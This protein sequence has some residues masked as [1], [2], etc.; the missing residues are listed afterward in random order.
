MKSTTRLSADKMLHFLPAVNKAK[1]PKFEVHLRIYDLNN[2]PLV[3]GVSQIK[4]HLPHSI[5]GEHRGRTGK[6]PISNHKV[7]YGYGKVVPVRIHIDRNNNLEECPIE[8]EVLQE[9]NEADERIVLGKVTLN[10]AEYVEESEAILRDRQ[11]PNPGTVSTGLGGIPATVAATAS[12]ATAA[13]ADQLHHQAGKLNLGHSR[14]RSSMSNDRPPPSPG[15]KASS[16]GNSTHQEVEAA[17]DVRE[18]IVRRHLMQESKINSTLKVGILMIQIDGDR[19]FVA[20][21]LKTAPVFG[22][23][24]GLGLTGEQ[25]DQD[26]LSVGRAPAISKSRDASEMHDMYR[27]S[28]AAAIVAPPSEGELTAD[29]CIE[30][31]FGGGSGFTDMD[32]EGGSRSTD[33]GGRS[34]MGRSNSNASA[35]K[36]HHRRQR[37]QRSAHFSAASSLAPPSILGRD[38]SG[39]GSPSSDN[40]G[41]SSAGGVGGGTLRPKD[42]KAFFVG[43]HRRQRSG[44]SERSSRTMLMAGSGGRSRSRGASGQEGES[45]HYGRRHRGEKSHHSSR[46][47]DGSHSRAPSLASFATGAS[48]SDSDG[49][50]RTR[51]VDEF[52]MRDDLI[53]WRLPGK[54]A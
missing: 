6:C 51:E 33:S 49:F 36:Y 44:A 5:H 23:I 16:A 9:F 17:S 53:S 47:R 50:R 45:D 7:E 39:N 54:V 4:W 1:K 32:G 31:I 26:E 48:S 40:D 24:A 13:V 14:H 18:G 43:G 2:V 3:N 42:V 12:A 38:D 25:G 29:A 19:N 11:D 15:S 10:L 34:G 8:F 52:E 41:S 30:D 22:G 46:S 21:P 27:T 37:S 28:L 20:P 35:H